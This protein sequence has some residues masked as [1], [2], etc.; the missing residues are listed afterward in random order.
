[1]KKTKL[2]KEKLVRNGE[3]EGQAVE[4][5]TK[6]I[7][8]NKKVQHPSLNYNSNKESNRNNKYGESIQ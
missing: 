6:H 1:M 3:K 7:H 8:A 4:A 5:V 2:I